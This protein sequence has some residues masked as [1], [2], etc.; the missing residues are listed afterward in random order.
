AAVDPVELARAQDRIKSLEK[1]NE[2]LK[3]NHEKQNQSP[4]DTKSLEDARRSLADANR[5]VSEQDARVAKLSL[6]K[7]ALEARLKH[8]SEAAPETKPAIASTGDNAHL[9][10]LEHERDEL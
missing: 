9:K 5:Q 6:E 7:E 2:L 1:E 8:V 3:V 10:E 4:T